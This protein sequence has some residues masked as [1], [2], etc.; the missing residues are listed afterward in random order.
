MA[1]VFRA[2]RKLDLAMEE[3]AKNPKLAPG[4]YIGLLEQKPKS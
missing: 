2:E 3:T 1:F 4:A